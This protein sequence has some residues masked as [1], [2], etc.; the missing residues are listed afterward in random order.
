MDLKG[1]I[2]DFTSEKHKIAFDFTMTWVTI[3]ITGKGD[4]REDV[5]KKLEDSDLNLMP[6]YTGGSAGET[7]LNTEM[8]WI[9]DKVDLR[10][11]K[12]AIG[13]KLIWKHRLRFYNSLES[14]IES[15]NTKKDTS[16]FTAEERALLEEIH[17][18]VYREAS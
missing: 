3:Y 9:D 13:S 18:S 17:A 1:K 4:F 7:D 10:E 5:G 6:G 12:G 15:Q 8:Y 11:I 2:K 14:F 16:E